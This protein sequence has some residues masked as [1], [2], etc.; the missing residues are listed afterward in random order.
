MFSNANSGF[1]H[2]EQ[3]YVYA[4]TPKANNPEGQFDRLVKPKTRTK[5]EMKNQTFEFDW[6]KPQAQVQ[7]DKCSVSQSQLSQ[8]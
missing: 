4:R 6:P 2:V 5:W 7:A 8:Y 1:K 3:T